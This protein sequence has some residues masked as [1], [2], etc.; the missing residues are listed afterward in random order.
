MKRIKSNLSSKELL[1]A[2]N[3]L[4]KA[5]IQEIDFN[6]I[7]RICD[8]LGCTHYEKGKKRERGSSECFTHPLL[9][10]FPDFNGT[11]SVHLKH[12]GGNPRKV[13][14][15]NFVNYT[16]PG[17]KIIAKLKINLEKK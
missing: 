3:E 13:Y 12:G 11:V 1:Q 14:K 16:A 8:Q 2:I 5:N 6:D 9:K 17:L 4:C 10:G 7:K 15:K